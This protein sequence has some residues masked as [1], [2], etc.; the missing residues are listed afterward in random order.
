VHDDSCRD[1][2]THA[3]GVDST[4]L[5]VEGPLD[6]DELEDQ[7]GDLPANYV[8]IKG[9]VQSGAGAWVA[10]HR[11]GL[12]VSVDPLPRKPDGLPKFGM[13]VALGSDLSSEKLAHCLGAA[14]LGD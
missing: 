4:S 5:E 7:L 2:D 12:R 8:R 11:V 13:I 10:I 14:Y 9:I 6:I 3:H 1:A